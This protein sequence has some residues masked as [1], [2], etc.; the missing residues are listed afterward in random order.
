[1]LVAMNLR[2]PI[3]FLLC[4]ILML[5]VFSSCQNTNF[6][7][8]EGQGSPDVYVGID[9]AYLTNVPAAE[10]LIDEVSPYTNFFVV[11]S[12][13]LCWAGSLGA[14]FQYAD[15]KGIS[16]MS[17]APTFFYGLNQS[18][19]NG[20]WSSNNATQWFSYAETNW[21]GR[22]LGFLDPVEDEPGG[23]ML[24]QANERPVRLT[25]ETNGNGVYVNSFA[26]AANVF[27][28]TYGAKLS[29]DRASLPNGTGY[30]LFTTMNGTEYPLFT[31][32][33]ALYWFDYKAGQDGVFAEFA[34]NYSR[35]L[36]VALNRGAAIQQGKQ[37]GVIIVYAENQPPYLE[38][39]PQLYDDMV[40]AYNSGAKYILIFDS[41]P[42]Y[43]HDIL[44]LEHIQALQKF[45]QYVQNNPRNDYPIRERTALVLPYGYGCGFRNPNDWVWGL[46]HA[47]DFSFGYNINLVIGN[48]LQTY[49][50]KLDIIY[51]DGLEPGSNMG[52][53]NL[54]YWNDTTL[55][56]SPSASPNPTPTAS[57]PPTPNP[58]S[59][60]TPLLSFSP[61]PSS[62]S[63]SSEPT[64]N[65]VPTLQPTPSS[66]GKAFLP[67]T[68]DAYL[69]VAAVILSVSI[70]VLLFI[71][72]NKT[73][74][75]NSR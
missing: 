5:S 74:A 75:T 38:S 12:E 29:T 50:D 61:A 28:N 40:T 60:P 62:P 56:P 68:L 9:M 41:D 55:L 33:Y 44:Q 15:D 3:L 31:S 48:L 30:P 53:Q 67:F 51:D 20:T 18:A 47:S 42:N 10:S 58:T 71:R 21:N 4:G 65:P 25:T 45:W 57:P 43:S 63:T 73:L 7:K 64:S 39:G 8:A 1:M 24:D 27:E 72:R 59:E 34:Y 19:Y 69:V 2:K 23:Q 35:Q 11:G 17:F 26:E 70:A 13:A 22:L 36:N 52:Y 49:G 6:L 66:N 37:W 14:I 16:F 54:I 32:D 46:W